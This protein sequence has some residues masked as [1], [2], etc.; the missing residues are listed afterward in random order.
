MSEIL[1]P[2]QFRRQNKGPLDVESVFTT[3][4]AMIDYLLNPKRYAGQQVSCVALDKSFILD[5]TETMWVESKGDKGDK[6]DIG[7]K[8]DT[9]FSPVP[10]ITTQLDGSKTL[11]F[12][13][14][15]DVDSNP[16]YSSEEVISSTSV[17][18]GGGSSA[19]TTDFTVLGVTQGIYKDGDVLPQDTSLELIIKGMLTNI[20]PPT[21][22]TPTVSVVST[23]ATLNVE[24][25]TNLAPLIKTTFN[26]KDGGAVTLFTLKKNN[27]QIF[28]DPTIQD[29]S[30]SQFPLIDTTTSYKAE[31][32]YDMGPIKQDNRG[33][34]S[35][36]GRILSGLAVSNT[37]IFTAKRNLFYGV[38]S[39]INTPYDLSS[40]I[41]ALADK[42]L[43]PIAGTN[44]T[45]NI[46][47]GAKMVVFAYQETLRDVSSVKYVE[48]SNS[49]V[50]G[51]FNKTVVNVDGANGATPVSY[52]LFTYIPAVPFES[53]VTY[54]VTI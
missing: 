45:L 13:T 8:G 41:R 39:D 38:D 14:G 32:N 28:S 35:P 33:V 51:I 50:K 16:I 52:K 29:F 42:F 49:E 24:S 21:Y 23:P 11:K 3:E 40:Q 31:I 5:S 46:P 30:D 48:F 10:V 4:Q 15:Y 47:A 36:L 18:E 19:L 54:N 12:I 22:E 53:P 37:I 9:G 7:L 6:G 1:I 44:F 17:V 27:V 2:V 43:G 34:D 25:G 20:I 26:Q